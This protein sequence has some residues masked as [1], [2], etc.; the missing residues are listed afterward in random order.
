MSVPRNILLISEHEA[1]MK[2]KYGEVS[3]GVVDG[4][5]TLTNWTGS[6]IVD[7]KGNLEIINFEFTC[8]EKF[9]NTE[10]VIKFTPDATQNTIAK[11]YCVKDGFLKEVVKKSLKWDKT[12]NLG[13]YFGELKTLLK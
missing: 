11:K 10:P 6:L 4:D 2:G 13:K 1:S 8:D 12:G 9:P 3:F 7:N 5:I